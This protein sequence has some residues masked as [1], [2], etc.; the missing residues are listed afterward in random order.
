M[1]EI[2]P[3]VHLEVPQILTIA[4]T[5]FFCYNSS[6]ICSFYDSFFL[7]S[8]NQQNFVVQMK[9]G[10]FFRP[11][12]GKPKKV[13][14]RSATV[15]Q[16]RE[17]VASVIR[18]LPDDLTDS[19]KQAFIVDQGRL[20]TALRTALKGDGV[21]I[22]TME[23]IGPENRSYEVHAFLR[24]GETSVIGHTM[25]KRTGE[26]TGDS[27]GENDGQY[28]LDNQKGIPSEF[29]KFVFV[30]QDWCHPGD[31]AR[32]YFVYWNGD[33]WVR[34][35]NWLDNHWNDNDRVLRRKSLHSLP[36]GGVFTYRASP[37]HLSSCRLRTM[38]W[39][40]QLAY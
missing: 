39:T 3:L 1:G 4:K 36:H 22:L 16:D 5:A 28:L 2:G 15:S 33:Q 18:Q 14:P 30:I 27:C 32:V 6:L 29:R 20:A 10:N 7:P 12:Q 21:T 11:K 9:V 8:F 24:D 17:F 26:M 35:W 23:S 13:S 25:I 31:S 37:T 34:N 19:E 40:K 38:D